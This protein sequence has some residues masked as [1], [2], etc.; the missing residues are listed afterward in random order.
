[1]SPIA[2][3]L[4]VSVMPVAALFAS[5]AERLDTRTRGAG[6]AILVAGGLAALGLMPGADIAWT[7]LP[8][9]LVGAGLGLSLGALTEAA[10]HGR[11]PLVRHGGWTIAARHLG[12]V[13][14]LALLTP[15]F[16]AD[17][18]REEDRAAEAVLGRLLDSR[19]EPST[20][21]TVALRLA[22][23][24]DAP[25]GEVPEVGPAFAE[26]AASPAERPELDRLRARVEDELDRAATSAFERSFL[27][28]ALL[29][30]GALPAVLL[31]P[32]RRAEE[33]PA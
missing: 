30:A 7:L 1:M 11:E 25:Q 15:V 2:A 4:T 17:L 31:A 26:T 23:L 33:A 32:R 29:A 16:A 21:L 28:A 27:I 14:A 13:A 6:G 19:L 8:Q 10:L 12:V 24:L 22:R 3:A 20:K 9:V 5:R 18:E